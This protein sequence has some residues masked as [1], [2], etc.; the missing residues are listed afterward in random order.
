M[1][2]STYNGGTYFPDITLVMPLFNVVGDEILFYVASRGHHADVGG[3]T[4][5]SMPPMSKTV[6]EEGV[7][8]DNFKL[9]ENGRMREAEMRELLASGPYPA[10]NPDQNIAD[11]QAQLAANEKGVQEL[12]RMVRTYGL[13]VVHAYMQHVQDNAEEAVRQVI[14]VL[15]DGQFKYELDNGA[16]IQV[17][18]RV[19]HEE[20]S[21]VVDF[22]GTSDQLEDNF[23]APSAVCMAAVLYVFRT[24]VNDEIPM[25]AG[26][27]KPLE[28]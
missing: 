28:V 21:A 15:K 1:L 5:G 16:H 7:L 10:R 2:N 12:H 17:A 20:R 14:G 26:C 4:P 18:V 23:N 22:T 6:V 13:D 19:N 9:V 8:I 25:N 24:L 3:I 11:L 27:L